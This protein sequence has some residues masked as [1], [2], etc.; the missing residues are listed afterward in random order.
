MN[1]SPPNPKT[2]HIST[3]KRNDL[4]VKALSAAF[5]LQRI[6]IACTL[7]AWQRYANFSFSRVKNV[8][9]HSYAYQMQ[10]RT[11]FKTWISSQSFFFFL[12]A[13]FVSQFQLRLCD[14]NSNVTCYGSLLCRE[15]SVHCNMRHLEYCMSRSSG[16]H[17]WFTVVPVHLWSRSFI[18]S[19]AEQL[20]CSPRYCH[21]FIAKR[22]KKNKEKKENLATEKHRD[23][24]YLCISAL[25]GCRERKKWCTWF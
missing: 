14:M 7:K 21:W 3:G 19:F 25:N 9:K 23:N 20:G 17:W 22:W 11:G 6:Y 18:L 15:K 4:H 8:C 2:G 5:L 10:R 12:N 24:V 13:F 16:L 1:H